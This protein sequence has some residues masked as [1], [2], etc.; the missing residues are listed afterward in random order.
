MGSK[1]SQPMR[2]ENTVEL[3]PEQQKIFNL[4]MPYASRYAKTQPKLYSGQTIAGFTP[5]E[6][7]GQQGAIDAATG[8]GTQL[9]TQAADTTKFLL[10]PALLDPSSNPHLAANG[11]A[12]TT[13]MTRNL[14]ESIL[15]G[16]RSGATMSGGAYS[17]GNTRDQMA[18][19]LAVGRT[20]E[21][22]GQSL[23]KLYGDAYN[24]GLGTMSGAVSMTPEVQAAQLFGPKVQAAVGAQQRSAEQAALDE[25]QSRFYL[26]QQLPL[27]KAQELMGLISGMPGGK[28]VSTVTPATPGTNPLMQGLGLGMSTLG[29]MGK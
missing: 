17:G 27:L 3:S 13:N 25:A 22:I 2:Q 4:A 29:M 9:A 6:V 12:I 15:P 18:E 23:S 10:N 24:Y 16:V 11:Q 28:G 20:N 26:Q 1:P 7:A 21:A 5:N 8:T 19:M 14:T